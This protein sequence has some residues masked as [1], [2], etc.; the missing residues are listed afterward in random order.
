MRGGEKVL[1]NLC[2]VYPK[3]DIFTHVLNRE[4]ISNTIKSHTI[5]TTFIN[6]LP[7]A[8]KIYRYYL[9]LMPLALKKINLESYD[10]IISSES[11]PAK[12]VIKKKGAFHLCYCHTPMRYIWDMENV[13]YP[14][15]NIFEKLFREDKAL[16]IRRG[17]WGFLLGIISTL[18]FY[19]AYGWIAWE[20]MNKSISLGGMTMYILLFKQGQAA[21]S[22]IKR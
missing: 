20:T 5:H 4:N 8:K 3:A 7:F 14:G 10:L 12:G 6:K 18:A 17:Q 16:T 19:G 13:Y 15:F 21:V 22:V 11:G 2:K 1:E 9:P